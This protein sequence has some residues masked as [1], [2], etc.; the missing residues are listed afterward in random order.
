MT[1][2]SELQQRTSDLQR[3]VEILECQLWALSSSDTSDFDNL[4]E[5]LTTVEQQGEATDTQ[6]AAQDST[7]VCRMR[8]TNAIR[9]AVR[10]RNEN[11]LLRHKFREESQRMDLLTDLLSAEHKLY[12]ANSTSFR[13][14]KPMTPKTCAAVHADC[15]KKVN[16]FTQELSDF[17][18]LS[19]CLSGWRE[20]RLVEGRLFKFKITKKVCNFTSK[21]VFS[22]FWTML[23]DP[24]RYARLYSDELNAEA[25]LIQKV[26][27]DNLVFYE[28]MRWM[29]STGT[30]TG[31][32][33]A[34]LLL[35]QLETPTGYRIQMR[36]LDR[37]QVVVEDLFAD[38]A[39]SSMEV[40]NTS[41]MLWWIDFDSAE[42]AC[43]VS[44]AGTTSTAVSPMSFWAAEVMRICLRGEHATIG[45]RF[46]LPE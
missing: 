16:A 42:D 18:P 30:K 17:M 46:S 45:A 24:T 6:S 28:E 3:Q 10:L 23:Q 34:V 35:S 9:E 31:C 39:S 13:L 32:A 43:V 2:S 4:E 20:M 25:R 5:P 8:L 33:K 44:F 7:S 40:W 19:G 11:T 22:R 12:L 15:I 21:T 41:E 14:L 38:T 26:D 29:D 37:D 27:D 1:A 36:G